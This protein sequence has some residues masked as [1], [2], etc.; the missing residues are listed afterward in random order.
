MPR[1]TLELT[2]VEYNF[3]YR[4]LTLYGWPSQVIQLSYSHPMSWS[5]TPILRLVWA[6]PLSLAA[7]DGI[8]FLSFPLGTK[9]F[10]V[11]RYFSSASIGFRQGD[12]M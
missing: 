7:T 12:E 8:D 11:P 5:V 6:V 2:M 9:M 1:R 4:T 10:Q 3:A